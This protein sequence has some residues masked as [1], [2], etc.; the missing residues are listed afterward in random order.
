MLVAFSIINGLTSNDIE[1]ILTTNEAST[2]IITICSLLK[3]EG[4]MQYRH[5]NITHY[6]TYACNVFLYKFWYLIF[7]YIFRGVQLGT[8]TCSGNSLSH[9][10]YSVIH[11]NA[12]SRLSLCR[13][14]RDT[15]MLG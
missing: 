11:H 8:S 14:A 9:L 4:L 7:V 3:T 12:T 5:Y 1:E 15:L 10:C 6:N 2:R 13:H